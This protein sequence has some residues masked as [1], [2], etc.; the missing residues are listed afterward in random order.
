VTLHFGHNNIHG[1]QEQVRQHHGTY[2]RRGYGDPWKCQL[3]ESH[4]EAVRVTCW[5][6]LNTDKE[7][8]DIVEELEIAIECKMLPAWDAEE[9]STP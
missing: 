8:R 2:E 7:S 3:C 1:A 6:C 9:T 5:V 4:N